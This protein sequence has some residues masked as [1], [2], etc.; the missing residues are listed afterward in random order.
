MPAAEN[1]NEMWVRLLK[2]DPESLQVM[3]GEIHELIQGGEIETAKG[4]L[5]TLIK[6]THKLCDS[7]RLKCVCS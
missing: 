4:M 3:I 2:E 6:V 5:R 7:P 1:I